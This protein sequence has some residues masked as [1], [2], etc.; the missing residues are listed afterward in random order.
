MTTAEYLRTDCNI[1]GDTIK[2]SLIFGN[3]TCTSA[4]GSSIILCLASVRADLES[5]ASQRY[6][7]TKDS[8]CCTAG[9]EISGCSFLSRDQIS[10]RL[11]SL[12]LSVGFL[13]AALSI[14]SSTPMSSRS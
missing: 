9:L 10:N 5:A 13:S 14:S 3:R 8:I 2:K 1:L 12:K 4:S 7:E 11:E 6:A